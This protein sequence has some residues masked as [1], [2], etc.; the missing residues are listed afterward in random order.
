MAE[1]TRKI[2]TERHPIQRTEYVTKDIPDGVILSLTDNEARA[3]TCLLSCVGGDPRTTA[4]AF[5]DNVRYALQDA[6]YDTEGEGC[7]RTHGVRG[8]ETPL[9]DTSIFFQRGLVE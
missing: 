7:L 6:G 8:E 5:A 2:R 9:F 1:A 4:R 3:L